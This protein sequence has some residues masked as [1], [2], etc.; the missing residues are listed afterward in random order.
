MFFSNVLMSLHRSKTCKSFFKCFSIFFHR[1]KTCKS[2]CFCMFWP[3]VQNV[4]SSSC[5]VRIRK[6]F[7]E[8]SWDAV[9]NINEI[10]TFIPGG[11]ELRV[12]E[13][14]E[15]KKVMVWDVCKKH[16]GLSNMTPCLFPV[17]HHSTSKSTIRSNVQ[18]FQ[19]QKKILLKKLPF[20]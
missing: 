1:P 18:P 6:N 19:W 8:T 20:G 14:A 5:L 17:S 9:D 13:R 7:K 3:D 4:F 16:S 15:W 11:S 2:F 10:H 12:G